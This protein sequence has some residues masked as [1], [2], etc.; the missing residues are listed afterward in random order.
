MFE[1]F[2]SSFSSSSL[3]STLVVVLST[4][5]WRTLRGPVKRNTGVFLMLGKG[6][7]GPLHRK[8]T[9][10]TKRRSTLLS[11]VHKS[12][13]SE[14]GFLPDTHSLFDMTLER[15]PVVGT[16]V[17]G[18]LRSDDCGVKNRGPDR[19]TEPSHRT[20]WKQ[21]DLDTNK[22]RVQLIRLHS[23]KRSWSFTTPTVGL[24]VTEGW[25][26]WVVSQISPTL[27]Q[28]REVLPGL[29]HGKGSLE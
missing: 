11:I 21:K 6:G 26:D 13:N 1:I 8:R 20:P 29:R 2:G 15:G 27:L 16:F 10:K 23:T 5:Y 9:K 17:Y 12:K 22:G 3:K 4:L 18:A 24:R 14:C 28:W 7:S 19:T 25:E